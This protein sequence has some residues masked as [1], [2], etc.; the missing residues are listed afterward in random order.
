MSYAELAERLAQSRGK[1][2]V[3]RMR[4]LYGDEGIA[5]AFE[6]GDWKGIS[7]A[8]Q[9][10]GGISLRGT[11]LLTARW[12]AQTSIAACNFEGA[13]IDKGLMKAGGFDQAIFDET[14]REAIERW[15]QTMSL[16]LGMD[17]DLLPAG[18]PPSYTMQ[19]YVQLI[20]ESPNF[21]TGAYWLETMV[22]T[23]G[24]ANSG[25][26][27]MVIAKK[28][29]DETDEDIN[30]LASPLIA[31]GE[32]DQVLINA[33]MG[34]VDSYDSAKYWFTTLSIMGFRPDIYSYNSLIRK[35][36]YES[37]VSLREDMEA[38][39][40]LPDHHTFNTLAHKAPNFEVALGVIDE[41]EQRKVPLRMIDFYALAF[42][43]KGRTEV[44]RFKKRIAKAELAPDIDCYN[45]LL[46]DI[47]SLDAAIELWNEIL[48]LGLTPD[49]HTA[50]SFLRN[51][52][53]QAESVRA[54]R[55]LRDSSEFPTP[56]QALHMLI[57]FDPN[58]GDGHLQKIFD[59]E[60]KHGQFLGAVCAIF[61]ESMKDGEALFAELFSKRDKSPNS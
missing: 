52:K 57:R 35:A 51:C 41:M 61:R 50:K 39:G 25:L 4:A 7:F 45:R 8:G 1:P 16:P 30:R 31:N 11:N 21:A 12:D 5:V 38:I 48:G 14:Q 56:G 53:T 40:L 27:T 46:S 19:Q 37:V 22:S 44:D 24:Q 23:G 15:H 13:L 54:F 34:N 2:I 49:Q 28:R 59:N 10:L 20:R 58:G 18:E 32:A 42:K 55:F 36:D 43:A 33:A 47:G 26:V 60:M 9:D 29:A 3:A 17:L 6:Y